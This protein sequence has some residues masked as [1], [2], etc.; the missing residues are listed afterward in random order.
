LVDLSLVTFV[1]IGME[2][3]KEMLMRY[4]AHYFDRCGSF[5]QLHALSL[6]DAEK[7]LKELCDVLVD[8][9]IIKL[10][11]KRCNGTM[12]I[13]NKYIDALERIGKRAKKDEL[14][15]EEIK[16]IIT[17]VEAS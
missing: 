13:L 2:R 8:I 9:E 1:L 4:S 17:K 14:T 7:I 6:E 12:R 16:D 5:C 3:A 15:F 10:I 11:H